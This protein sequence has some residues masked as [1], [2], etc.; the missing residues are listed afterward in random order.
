[1]EKYRDKKVNEHMFNIEAL[2][3]AI[4]GKETKHLNVQ[5]ILK[6]D[7]LMSFDK[8]VQLGMMETANE[9][10]VEV[11]VLA[12][13]LDR[14]IAMVDQMADELGADGNENCHKY[15]KRLEVL[16]NFSRIKDEFKPENT[17]QFAQR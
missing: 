8:A 12:T 13:S 2:L 9:A 7:P 3:T 1:M 6:L 4:S 14:I 10:I 17:H 11:K 15:R 5:D 16:T